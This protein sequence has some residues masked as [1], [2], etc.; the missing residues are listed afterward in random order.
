MGYIILIDM[1]NGLFLMQDFALPISQGIKFILLLLF[2]VRLSPTGD[3]TF[4]ILLI[5]FFQLSP[6]AGLIRNGDFSAYFG[7]VVF[8]AKWINVP[9]S[10]LYFKCLFQSAYADTIQSSIKRMVGRNFIFLCVNMALGALGLGMSFYFHGYANAVGTKG[11]IYAGNE[12]TILVLSLHFIIGSYWYYKQEYR[13]Y[14]GLFLVFLAISFLITSKTVLI[15][16]LVVG[17]IPI[18]ASLRQR[19]HKKW[20]NRISAL[21]LFG[22]PIFLA[23]I[24]LGVTRSGVI[25]KIQYSLERNNFD[26]LTVVLSNRNRFVAEGWDVFSRDFSWFGQLFGFGQH[27]HLYLSG[28][29]AEVD[30]FTILFASGLLGLLFLLILLLFW[31]LNAQK[32]MKTSGYVLA[33]NT[34]LFLLFLILVANLAGHI[35]GS[36]IAGIFIGLSIALM[37]FKPVSHG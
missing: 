9:L 28:H 18:I 5:V 14:L 29:S 2:L 13:K 12:L 21:V 3:F 11:F 24:Y 37:H 30:F 8:A 7:D 10:Y 22:T 16:V 19:I 17:A 4:A 6:V 23:L 32:L 31:L 34:W 26:L 35:F 27:H 25:D 20:I 1:V 33:K 15:G 36:G